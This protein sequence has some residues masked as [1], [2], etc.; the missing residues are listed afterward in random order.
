M[1]K[2]IPDEYG[3]PLTRANMHINGFNL[4]VVQEP[5]REHLYEV[6][7]LDELGQFVRIAGIYNNDDDVLRYLSTSEVEDIMQRLIDGITPV[8]ANLYQ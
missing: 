1:L 8:P 6:A 4:S 7:I 3:L 2:F 5:N